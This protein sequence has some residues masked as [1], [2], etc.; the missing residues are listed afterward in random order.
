MRKSGIIRAAAAACLLVSA[1]GIALVR[2]QQPAP[3]KRTDLVSVEMGGHVE[4]VPSEWSKT[5]W[6]AINLLGTL[7]SSQGAWCSKDGHFPHDFPQDLVFSFFGRQLALVTAV[8]SISRRE[9][10]RTSGRRTSKSGRR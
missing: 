6:A 10:P 1:G 9:T 4:R 8:A 3:A 5:D 7:P 2:A